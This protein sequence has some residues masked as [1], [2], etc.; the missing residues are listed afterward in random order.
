VCHPDS[1]CFFQGL[2]PCLLSYPE[3]FPAHDYPT[4]PRKNQWVRV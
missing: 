4:F 2:S 3:R 1:Q